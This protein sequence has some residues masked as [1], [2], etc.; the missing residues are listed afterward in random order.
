MDIEEDYMRVTEGEAFMRREVLRHQVLLDRVEG[1]L[2]K[3]EGVEHIPHILA[4]S[5]CLHDF[6][7]VLPTLGT[8]SPDDVNESF[9]TVSAEVHKLQ[10][11]LS[12]IGLPRHRPVDIQTS[13]AGPGVGTSERLVRIRNA[14]YFL[15]NDLDMQCR[16]HYAP[17]DS[18]MHCVERVMSVLNEAAGDG[19]AIEINRPTLFQEI[20]EECLLQMSLEEF[21]DFEANR[22]N[23]IAQDCAQEVCARYQGVKCMGTTIKACTPNYESSFFFDEIFMKKCSAASST[24]MLESLPGSNYYQRMKAF[25]EDHYIIYDNGMEGIKDACKSNPCRY[26]SEPQVMD[27]YIQRVPAPVPDYSNNDQFSYL[28]PQDI[29]TG[30]ITPDN[31]INV[32]AIECNEREPDDFCPRTQLHALIKECGELDLQVSQHT[33]DDGSVS[34]STK[35]TN[36][37]MEKVKEKLPDF[38][39]KY[40]GDDLKDEVMD[41][42][43][44]DY[45]RKVKMAVR[46]KENLQA[47]E[48]EAAK[49]VEDIDWDTLIKTASLNTL[50]VAQLDL[51]LM[52][53]IGKSTAQVRKTG[54]LKPAKIMDIT[55]HFYSN[56]G[57][58]F[59]R[60]I[61]STV[62]LTFE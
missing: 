51:Y 35:D 17:R 30:N 8:E 24:S 26:H 32:H 49:G 43:E 21:K 7:Q 10:S 31:D 44:N 13:D 60:E 19:T 53:I 15:I 62:N 25:V 54:Y 41:Y 23:R 14:E 6:V 12:R 28:T 11:Y 34:Y 48:D 1:V 45:V 22:N 37:T 18:K 55:A 46:K 33:N 42:V 50:K 38:I 52:E 16:F 56:R 20:G 29:Q 9:T 36:N 47:R 5:T 3:L 58:I 27:K 40:C 2:E 39:L 61:S 59:T 4:L 57:K